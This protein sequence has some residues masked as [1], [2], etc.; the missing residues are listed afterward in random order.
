MANSIQYNI[1]NDLR[2]VLHAKKA[3]EFK[4]DAQHGKVQG[5]GLKK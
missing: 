1:I 2:F 3:R 4:G 5:K